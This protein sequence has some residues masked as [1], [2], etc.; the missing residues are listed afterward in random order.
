MLTLSFLNRLATY[1]IHNSHNLRLTLYSGCSLNN[2]LVGPLYRRI[3]PNRK[4][5]WSCIFTCSKSSTIHLLDSLRNPANNIA[6]FSQPVSQYIFAAKSIDANALHTHVPTV[7]IDA[8][9]SSPQ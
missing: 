9:I 3:H 8:V 5:S 6:T 4:K 7:P 2:T 1:Q